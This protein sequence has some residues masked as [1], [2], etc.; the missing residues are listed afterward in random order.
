VTVLYVKQGAD[1]TVE[2]PLFEPDGTTPLDVSGW[3]VRGQVRSY[4]EAT[5]PLY[6]LPFTL[7]T[8]LATLTIPAAAAS[9]LWNWT[10]VP[11]DAELEDPSGRVTRLDSGIVI[12]SFEVTR[13]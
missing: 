11:W 2:W 5:D 8:G 4:V 10:R 9:D 12:V 3:T 13:S 7:A 1:F 6:E